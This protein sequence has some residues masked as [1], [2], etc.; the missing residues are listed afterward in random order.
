MGM[1][2]VVMECATSFSQTNCMRK[3]FICTGGIAKGP[4][5]LEDL[6]NHGL[7]EWDLIWSHEWGISKYAIEMEELKGYFE[8]NGITKHLVKNYHSA[9][10]RTGKLSIKDWILF[11][12]L[13]ALLAMITYYF[14]TYR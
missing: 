2:F 9:V 4:Y 3:F 1:F 14:Y 12:L 13:L 8:K 10:T 6:L 11:T 7:N 5:Q